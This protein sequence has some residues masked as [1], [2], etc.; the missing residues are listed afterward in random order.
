MA[1]KI[2]RF[3]CDIVPGQ[4]DPV[5]T[6]FIGKEDVDEET[7]AQIVRMDSSYPVSL[8]ISQ[9]AN[10]GDLTNHQKIVD[11]WQAAKV[12]RQQERE[13]A[14]AAQGGNSP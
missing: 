12:V 8:K 11:L 5:I 10:L 9:L 1:K 4:A 3:Q 2:T 14:A 13:A 6:F 7:G